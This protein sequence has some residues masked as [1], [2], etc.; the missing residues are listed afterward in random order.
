MRR[1][2]WTTCV[3]AITAVLLTTTIAFAQ[4]T[5]S[6][7][8][9][10]PSTAIVLSAGACPG[11]TSEYTAA[12]GFYLVAVPSGGTVAGTLGTA[13]ANGPPD[14]SY[15]PA[16]TVAAPTFTG[17]AMGTHTHDTP[18]ST[19]GLT[20]IRGG[21]AFGTGSSQTLDRV[22]GTDAG[23]GAFTTALTSATGAGTPA[24]TNTAPAFTGTANATLRSSVAP[25]IQLRL[26]QQ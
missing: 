24:G 5:I 25:A 10:L 18:L 4:T 21:A 14:V 9:G 11:A 26:C 16:G 23:T 17:S 19:D 3:S 1:R 13:M 15:T 8:G 12:R 20:E 7:G 6:G 22:A 2:L